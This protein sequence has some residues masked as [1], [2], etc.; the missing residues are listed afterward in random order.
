MLRK[1]KRAS[2]G[3]G[4]PARQVPDAGVVKLV[5][6]HDSKSCA[7]RHES[8]ILSRGTRIAAGYGAVG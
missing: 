4:I 8:S 2:G 5:Y 1:A 3:T 6:T 7:E